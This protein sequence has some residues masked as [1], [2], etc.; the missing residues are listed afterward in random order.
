M[1]RL[2]VRSS[3]AFMAGALSA[4]N[5]V[6]QT[7]FTV[8]RDAITEDPDETEPVR[9]VLKVLTMQE[10]LL[11]TGEGDTASYILTDSGEILLNALK[12]A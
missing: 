6:T 4:V 2:L 12:G 11:Q 7:P 3:R 10:H 1:A 9:K 5:K 8:I